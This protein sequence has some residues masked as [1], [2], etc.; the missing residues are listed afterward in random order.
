MNKFGEKSKRKGKQPIHG[1]FTDIDYKIGEKGIPL[2]LSIEEIIVMEKHEDES[3]YTEI[4]VEYQL[5][6]TSFYRIVVHKAHLVQRRYKKQLDRLFQTW[7]AGA[8]NTAETKI[9]TT[10]GP[11]SNLVG[12]KGFSL[13]QLAPLLS[14]SKLKDW[15][16]T[17]EALGIV[18]R[19]KCSEIEE[20][21]ETELALKELADTIRDRSMILMAILKRRKEE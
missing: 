8:K 2:R 4:E 5:E 1:S 11:K 17:H 12:E 9:I 20:A 16:M 18:Y 19:S 7:L 13:S 21:E 15:V 14:D 10:K 3:T 6:K